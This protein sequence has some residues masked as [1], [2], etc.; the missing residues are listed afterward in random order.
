MPN[1]IEPNRPMAETDTACPPGVLW[2]HRALA[3]EQRLEPPSNSASPRPRRCYWRSATWFWLNNSIV[4]WH[5]VVDG[6]G[7]S[8]WILS[9][10]CWRSALRS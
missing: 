4:G 6:F 7:N 8:S 5:P 3:N 2:R 10:G 1:T 9:T